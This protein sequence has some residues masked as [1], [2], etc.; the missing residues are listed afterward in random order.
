MNCR[1][2]FTCL[3][4]IIV[5]L[6]AP[7]KGGVQ[8]DTGD[9]KVSI[10]N[11]SIIFNFDLKQGVYSA[12]NLG[13]GQEVLSKAKFT[14]DAGKF[15]KKT[16]YTYSWSQKTITDDFGKGK[17][18]SIKHT[19]KEGNQLEGQLHITLYNDQPFAIL[20]FSVI[21]T[22]AY[23]VRIC[24]VVLMDRAKI[25]PNQ[26]VK[27]PQVLRGG[28]GAQSNFVENKFDISA[29]NSLMLTANINNKRN[30]VVVGGNKY[31]DFFRRVS[32]DS[33]NSRTITVECQDPQ[34]KYIAPNQTYHSKDSVYLDFVTVDPFV[35]LEQ[36]GFAMR[37]ANNAKPN[38]YN[39]PDL[40]G[41]YM[42]TAG[43]GEGKE[44]NN[45]PGLVEQTRLAKEAGIMKYTPIGVRLVPD[46]Y[47]YNN[48]GNTQQGWWDDEHWST[49]GGSLGA[50]LSSLMKPYDT[51]EKFCR[52]VKELG[53]VPL[54]YIQASMP[55]NDFAIAHPEWMLNNDI[56]R[57][58]AEHRHHIPFVTFDYTDPGFQ[59]YMLD[60]W[61]RQR[62][63]GLEGVMFD[64]PETGWAKNGGFEDKSY[65][66]TSAYRKMFELCREGLG[67]DAYI[68]ERN[69]GESGAPMLDATVGIVDMQR[70]WWDASHFEPEMASRMGLRWYKNRVVF[71]Y[72]PDSKSLYNQKTKKPLPVDDR[73]TMLTQVGLLSGRLE[74]ATSFGSMTDEMK[75][76]ITRLYPVL[77]EPKSFRPV[78]MLLCDKHP[79]VYVYDIDPK[80][81]QVILCNNDN[82][83][84][85]VSAPFSG[86]QYETGSLGMKADKKY[87]VYDFWNN[88]LIGK[89]SGQDKLSVKLAKYQSLVYSVHEVKDH[90][91][92]ISTNR[93]VMQGLMELHD[94]NWDRVNKIYSGRV[95]VIGGETMEIVIAL[96]GYNTPTANSD[97]GIID[98][99]IIGNDLAQLKI[100]CKDNNTVNWSLSF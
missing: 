49:I 19:P 93:H 45:S 72:Y 25:F 3:L 56:S 18:L 99:E 36:F 95:D 96:N 62:A 68:H 67:P 54:N 21:N 7:V 32:L 86:V 2:T 61:K 55:S 47:C 59:K 13:T 53:G 30:T 69:L 76:D 34:G 65:T 22:K 26:E 50:R 87:Y 41:W 17:T 73:I 31:C 6:S 79:G 71:S 78:D 57:V 98:L 64:Y 29:Y 91:Q 84:Q 74:L 90:P 38:M 97:S 48:Y 28:A 83:E 70:V 12:G 8:I 46:L 94:V 63:D 66:T 51:L 5:I 100:D 37:T 9:N 39:F 35:S 24:D 33:R 1:P 88:A 75:H 14:I 11:D 60:S 89:F 20:G 27:K 10:S 23:P 16:P 42:S 15:R 85:V 80:W 82:T 77:Q 58:H 4:L 52:A 44:L 40:C 92:F 43:Y 81:S